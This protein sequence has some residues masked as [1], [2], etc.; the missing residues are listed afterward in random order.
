MA[1]IT[2]I[3]SHYIVVLHAAVSSTIIGCQ[4]ILAQQCFLT[5]RTFDFKSTKMHTVV[6]L[7]SCSHA[8]V[9][10]REHGWKMHIV[11]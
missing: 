8:R 1:V 10:D 6:R 3:C 2:V 4:K 5:S 11:V 7:H 9:R